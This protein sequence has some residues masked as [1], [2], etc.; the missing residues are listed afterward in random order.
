MSQLVDVAEGSLISVAAVRAG[1]LTADEAARAGRDVDVG[2]GQVADAIQHSPGYR[3]KARI[4]IDPGRGTV[5]RA[6]FAGRGVAELLHSAT[7]AIVGELPLERLW[8]AVPCFP[9]IS[10]VW[11]RLL[12]TYRDVATWAFRAS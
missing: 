2:I 4:L 11:L 10:E 6:T 12:E 5:V 1:A 7:L 8:H 3:A 9:A